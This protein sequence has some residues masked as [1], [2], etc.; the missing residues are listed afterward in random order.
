MEQYIT[1]HKIIDL[2][3]SYQAA[4][5]R[6][7]SFGVGEVVDFGQNTSGVSTTYPM[8]FVV[9]QSIIYNENTTNYQLSIIFGDRLNDDAFNQVDAITDMQLEG[10]QFISTIKRGYLADYME[11]EMPVNAQPFKERFNDFIAGVALDCNIT[12]YEDINACI[13]YSG[14]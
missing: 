9:P 8:M 1:Y 7:N 10:R 14:I 11:I 3:N 6:L 13:Y 2:L 4:S 12:V 5:P